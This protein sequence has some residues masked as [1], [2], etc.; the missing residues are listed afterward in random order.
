MPPAESAAPGGYASS[1]RRGHM[2]ALYAGA[3]NDARTHHIAL[4]HA[5][6][7]WNQRHLRHDAPLTE[8]DVGS[9]FAPHFVVQPNGRRYEANTRN[10]LEFLNG[11]RA[12]MAGIRYE[13]LHTV[14]DAESVVFDLLVQITHT[15]GRV[16]HFVAMLLM[17][18]DAQGKVL[19]WKETYLPQP[20][21]PGAAGAEDAG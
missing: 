18:F 16:E 12:S 13:V 7:D 11:M 17:R 4:A 1:M 3:M 6:L 14:A 21:A 9:R 19:L 15:D 5:V 8:A 20:P 10:Y 2:T